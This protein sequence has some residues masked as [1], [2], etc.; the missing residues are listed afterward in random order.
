[1][2]NIQ[3]V[4]R[5]TKAL[6]DV[7]VEKG[8]PD[9]VEKDLSAIADA[10]RNTPEMETFLESKAVQVKEKEAMLEEL[11]IMVQAASITR[12]Y[13]SLILENKRFSH[14]LATV[15]HQLYQQQYKRSQ[16]IKKG[17]IKLPKEIGS[18][19]EEA[20]SNRI[21]KSLGIRLELD[22]RWDENL[23]DG[24]CLEIDGQVYEDSVQSRLRHFKKWIKG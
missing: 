14:G 17:I 15:A 7:A 8:L 5:Y 13:Y 19:E 10:F 24:V 22:F 6:F 20:L 18:I 3:V 1:M 16:G 4:E 12:G 2:S 23:L 21:A 11:M 9:L